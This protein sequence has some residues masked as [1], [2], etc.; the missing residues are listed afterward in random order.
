MS[1][2][3][4]LNIPISKI[5][6]EQRTVTGIATNESLDSQGDIVD[7]EAS[8][9]A[10]SEWSGNIR[11]MHNPVA[12]GKGID[13]Q[14]NDKAKE[15]I[16]TAK[17]SESADGQN[18][19]TKVKEEVLTGFSIGGRVFEVAKDKAVEGAN[20]ILDYAL[21]ELSL[22]DNPANPDAQLIMV[23]SA[24][25]KL[26]RVE[27]NTM[28]KSVYDAA[29][30]INLATQ[31]TYLIMC[32]GDEPDQQKDLLTAFNS[33]RDFIGKEIAEG[34]DFDSAGYADVIEMAQSAINLR[35]GTMSK[36]VKKAGIAVVDGDPRD[37]TGATVT[38]VTAS[39]AV[40]PAAIKVPK[41]VYARDGVSTTQK[42]NVAGGVERDE[43]AKI[44]EDKR[45]ENVKATA[46]EPVVA[47]VVPAEIPVVDEATVVE[48]LV[49][50]T[51]E[52][53]VPVAEPAVE[54]A[55]IV[56]PETVTPPTEPVVE[57]PVVEAPVVEA[58]P[59]ETPVVDVPVTADT[60]AEVTAPVVEAPV[61]EAQPVETPVVDV[62]VTADT[63]AEVTAPVDESGKS[64][65]ASD[66]VKNVET[67]L[68]KL[69][70]GQGSDLKK[71]AD[72][73]SE[74]GS[75]VEKSLTSLEERLSTLEKTP[76]PTKAKASYH[77][78]AKGESEVAPDTQALL[79]RQE[80]LIAHPELAKANEMYELAVAL[81]KA[82]TGERIEIK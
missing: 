19:W 48:A 76:L 4:Y 49:V 57:T 72:A 53:V 54:V 67:L 34:D 71:V 37:H 40:I 33:L 43:T 11:E 15:V 69:N 21:S 7:Y 22:V 39:P 28:Q 73:V 20:R 41:K 50:E 35:K 32:E 29:A 66:L 10:F 12:I 55:P 3:F 16:V 2:T 81:R 25:G 46:I 74:L 36:D 6:E 14:F 47:E 63:P 18:A 30:A 65:S 1:K 52:V 79:N 51:P 70:D 44:V 26:Q 5:D 64:A 61:V 42:T 24:D 9:K 75:K 38:E 82:N 62:P 23:K 77:V 17:I 13:V 80:E 45:P 59:V 78:V 58:Q 8:K 56:D 31:L 27:E 60:P 68:A